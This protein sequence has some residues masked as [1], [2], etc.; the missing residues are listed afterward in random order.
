MI[1]LESKC[2]K[3]LSIHF[4]NLRQ[5]RCFVKTMLPQSDT[6]GNACP[7]TGLSSFFR[8]R[9]TKGALYAWG[10]FSPNSAFVGFDNC[11]AD[12][13]PQ[14]GSFRITVPPQNIVG[15]LSLSD[16]ARIRSGSCHACV[17]SRIRVEPAIS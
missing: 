17:S 15:V 12:G 1:K 11:F 7:V 2:T 16:A 3:L 5:K 4:L 6:P 8:E 14:A 9:E 13:K 10:A